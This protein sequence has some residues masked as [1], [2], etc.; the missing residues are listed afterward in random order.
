MQ[1]YMNSQFFLISV[2]LISEDYS[3]L[4]MYIY[5]YN[6][7]EEFSYLRSLQVYDLYCDVCHSKGRTYMMCDHLLW[8]QSM[9]IR[10]HC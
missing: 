4:I 8:F 6:F 9:H 5:G 2:S 1:T 10:N 7:E 3:T